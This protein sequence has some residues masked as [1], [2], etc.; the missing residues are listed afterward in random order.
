VSIHPWQEKQWQQCQQMLS[1]DRLGHAL[2]FTGAEGMGKADFARAFA[3]HLLGTAHPDFHHV[4]VEEKASTIKIDQ[5]RQ[6]TALSQK[7]SFG[8]GF[9]IIF[10]EQADKMT[11]AA[12]NALLKTLEE[13]T[14]NS[15]IMLTA[16]S[17]QA[18]P[19]TLVSRV[20]HIH[21]PPGSRACVASMLPDAD[22][23]S[24]DLLWRLTDGAPLLA[25]QCW[26]DDSLSTRRAFLQ[27]F[28][29]V[30]LKQQSPVVWAQA[31]AKSHL[32][33]H[34]GWLSHWLSDLIKLLSQ[35]EPQ[36]CINHDLLAPLQKC[37]KHATISQVFRLWDLVQNYQGSLNINLNPQLVLSDIAIGLTQNAQALR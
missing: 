10:I 11:I 27:D 17:R 2:L 5:I 9:K 35:L 29:A 24:I 18:L 3:E 33:T 30:M 25:Q 23:A 13:P 6:V 22:E 36:S 21:F 1:S 37:A 19:A 28:S 8:G 32:A 7:T 15:L 34:L 16:T 26:Q 14:P 20:Q 31:Y 12:A 4:T